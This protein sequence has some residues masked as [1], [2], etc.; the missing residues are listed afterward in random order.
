MRGVAAALLALALLAPPL[1]ADNEVINCFGDSLTEGPPPF[2][3]EGRGGY[4]LRMQPLV[5]QGGLKNAVVLNNGI[6]G[7]TT[8]AMLAR[9]DLDFDDADIIIILGG[10]NDIADIAGG[11]LTFEDVLFNLKAMVDNAL[12]R[13]ARAILGTLPPR[14]PDVRVDRGNNLTYELVLR[15][16]EMAHEH[17]IELVDFWDLFPNRALST[18]ELYYYDGPDRTGHPNAAGFQRMAEAAAAVVLEEDT[19]RPVEGRI[20][21][22]LRGEVVNRNTVYEIELYDFGTGLR[23]NSASVVINGEPV[24]TTVT[25][26]RLKATLVANSDRFKRCKVLYSVE[27]EDRAQ[28]PNKLDLFIRRMESANGDPFSGD[29]NGDCRVD[30]RDLARLGRTF[31][32]TPLDVGYDDEYDF[33]DD[34]VIDGEDFARLAANF[35]KS[36]P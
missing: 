29:G 23:V 19:Q 25:G 6:G 10:T 24:D 15:I 14:K 1:A 13:R 34:D 26:N 5:R 3:E 30:G 33:V 16:R 17:G 36:A 9:F 11:R 18:Y 20:I 31:G 27:A 7:Q 32:K 4:P 35:G 8:T 2:D 28:P 12:G 22:P 21:S